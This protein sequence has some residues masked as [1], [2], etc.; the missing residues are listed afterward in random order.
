MRVSKM[1]L[2]VIDRRLEALR[3]TKHGRGKDA[4]IRVEAAPV[5]LTNWFDMSVVQPEGENLKRVK[6]RVARKLCLACGKKYT[7]HRRG[8]CGKCERLF[9]K[10]VTSIK[11][12]KERQAWVNKQIRAG[13]LLEAHQIK[14]I[15]NPDECPF[16]ET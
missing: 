10:L 16:S 2:V 7:R 12:K 13:K 8:C 6:T 3:S 14:A 1:C 11:G 15:K 5:L 9:R 4:A